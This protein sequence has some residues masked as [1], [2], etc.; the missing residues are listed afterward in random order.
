MA[1]YKPGQII[2]IKGKVCRVT[3]D[4][5]PRELPCKHCAFTSKCLETE[6]ELTFP[7]K[8]ECTEAIGWKAHLELINPKK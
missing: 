7:N 3:K 2:T 1:T 6:K 8:L 5:F 4:E